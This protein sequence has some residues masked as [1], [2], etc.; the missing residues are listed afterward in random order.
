M[1]KSTSLLLTA[2][3]IISVAESNA[4]ESGFIINGGIVRTFSEKRNGYIANM[5]KFVIKNP[6]NKEESKDRNASSLDKSDIWQCINTDLEILTGLQEEIQRL[7]SK[8]ANGKDYD[9]QDV[10]ELQ[11][12]FD[13][14]RTVLLSINEKIG[15]L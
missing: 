14:E 4:E 11:N 3:N 12:L 13:R 10:V 9:T 6:E 5:I 15:L 8:I 7:I 1:N 2:K